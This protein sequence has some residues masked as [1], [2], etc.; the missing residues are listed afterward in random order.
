M[1]VRDSIRHDYVK[2]WTLV[3]AAPPAAPAPEGEEKQS[4]YELI[5]PGFAA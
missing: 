4:A 5:A 1:T 2:A 3:G